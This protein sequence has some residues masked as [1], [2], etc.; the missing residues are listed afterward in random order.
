MSQYL[1]NVLVPNGCDTPYKLGPLL[2]V[3]QV[4]FKVE[5]LSR[6]FLESNPNKMPIESSF[7]TRSKTRSGLHSLQLPL[8]ICS[9]DTSRSAGGQLSSSG[10]HDNRTRS[11]SHFGSRP[12]FSKPGGERDRE[13]EHR[14]RLAQ[15]SRLFCRP[16]HRGDIWNHQRRRSA[17]Y[18]A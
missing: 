6:L 5:A 15:S 4:S 14:E 2:S 3:K 12:L 9:Y 11:S 13:R 7:V 8:F 1:M 10:L 17:G 16:E 18:E